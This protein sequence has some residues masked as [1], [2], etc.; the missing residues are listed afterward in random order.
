[1]NEILKSEL[2]R[3]DADRIA[4]LALAEDGPRDITS[5]VTISE[6]VQ[7]TARI[8]A[9]SELVMAGSPWAD[10]I[11]SAVGL[12][13]IEWNVADGDR[14]TANSVV[15]IISGPLRQILR[16][17]RP[18]LNL[19]QRA[20]GIAT[21]TAAAVQRVAGTGCVILH[22]RKTTP[23]LRLLEVHSVLAGGG[24]LHRTELAS[25]VMV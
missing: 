23:G 6:S 13:A 4:E 15:G 16:A 19:L 12:P 2:V 20:A 17:E 11:V 14:C 3:I 25:T 5:L 22:T 24:G 8:E 10:A 9:R 21:L 7:G 18:L 1:M